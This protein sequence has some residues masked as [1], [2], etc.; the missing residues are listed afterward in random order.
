MKQPPPMRNQHAGFSQAF[1][2]AAQLHRGGRLDQAESAY[3]LILSMQPGHFDAAH[4]MGI[5]RLQ[6]GRHAEAVSFFEMALKVKPKDVVAQMNMGLAYALLGRLTDALESYDRALALKPDYADALANRG[7]VLVDLRRPKDA[8]ASYDKALLYKSRCPDTLNNRGGVLMAL[9][10]AQEA[11][12]SF[13]QAIALKPDHV[14]A[15]NNRGNALMELKRPDAA[16]ASYDKAL[17]LKPTH[18]DTLNNRGNALIAL[19]RPIDALASYDFAL[20]LRPSDA[21]AL[22]NRAE[23]LREL[24]R[25]PEAI[26]SC[27]RALALRPNWVQALVNRGNAFRDLARFSEA[28]AD[29]ESALRQQPDCVLA[30]QNRASALRD[31]GRPTEAVQ[32]C[33]SALALDPN[34]AE[35]LNIRA[36][37]LLDLKRPMEALTSCDRALSLKTDGAAILTNRGNALRALKREVEALESYDAALANEPSYALAHESRA[38]LLAE[39]GRFGEAHKAFQRAIELAPA[40]TRPYFMLSASKRMTPNDPHLIAMEELAKDIGSLP[41]DDQLYLNFALAKAFSDIGDHE[42]S[43]QKLIAGNLLERRRV[44]YDEAGTLAR[45]ERIGKVFT[46][47]L[48]RKLQG[49]GNPATAP[50]FIVGMPRSGTSLIEQ[51]LASHGDVFGAGETHHFEEAITELQSDA[52]TIAL[53]PE[54]VS[55][56]TVEQLHFLGGAYV[57]KT[58][59]PASKANRITEKLPGNFL[60]AGLIHVALPNAR[61]IHA[62]R[63]PVDACFSCFSNLFSDGLPWASDLGELGRYYRA[64]EKLMAHWREVL[65]SGVMLEVQYEEVVRDLE[66]Q[67]R[68]I[69]D[70]CGLE[71]DARCLDFHLTDRAV[72][73]ASVAQVRQPIYASSVG[74]WRAYQNFLGPLVA[75]LNLEGSFGASNSA[76]ERKI[77]A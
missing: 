46:A 65:P 16:L 48:V 3:R 29:Y 72:R 63:D 12:T 9:K 51:I 41:P 13:D 50:V 69:V 37:A 33:D 14:L 61:I 19:K 59:P 57:E 42:R 34:N 10:R 1:H 64:Y 24:Q 49:A 66:G 17:A 32:S 58:M 43:V 73:T 44:G 35:V 36:A 54:M 75:E 15:H 8:L 28:L 77:G 55:R 52:G 62:R 20:A 40:K 5:M 67:A 31:L 53:Y 18:V 7:N 21:D 47:D 22:Y 26:A 70:Y 76:N 2:N 4:Q 60:F 39:V 25:F 71:W 56:L 27:D 30:H 23:A 6:L 68:R 11:L 45:I 38:N 74:R